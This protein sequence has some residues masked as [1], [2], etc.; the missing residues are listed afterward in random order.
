M[1]PAAAL[2]PNRLLSV[3]ALSFML[4]APVFAADPAPAA[5]K[6]D[7]AKGEATSTNVCAACHSA[8]GSRGAHMEHTV[9][10]TEDGPIILTARD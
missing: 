10:I 2:L 3:A 8:D 9:A 5:A 1:K 7:L 4:S 6:P